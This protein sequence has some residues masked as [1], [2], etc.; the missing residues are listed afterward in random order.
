MEI[1]Y[2]CLY[3]FSQSLYC[4]LLNSKSYGNDSEKPCLPRQVSFASSEYNLR[5]QIQI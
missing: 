3:I 1:F 2:R 5:A 4:G